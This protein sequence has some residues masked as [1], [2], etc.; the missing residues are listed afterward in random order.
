MSETQRT[1]C[2]HYSYGE[3]WAPGALPDGARI[4]EVDNCPGEGPPSN[5]KGWLCMVSGGIHKKCN[6]YRPRTPEDDARDWNI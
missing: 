4:G 1:I 3:C 2:G 6:R 5:R